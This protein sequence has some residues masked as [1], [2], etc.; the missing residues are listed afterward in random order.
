MVQFSAD[1]GNVQLFS[2]IL[3]VLLELQ[4]LIPDK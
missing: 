4:V 1:L 3:K 2:F